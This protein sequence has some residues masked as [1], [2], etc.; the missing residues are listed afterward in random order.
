[1]AE[2]KE[3]SAPAPDDNPSVLARRNWWQTP[4]VNFIARHTPKCRDVTRLL[5]RGMD[6]P[7]P[8]TTRL[9]L[10]THFLI[11]CWCQRY[12]TQLKQMRRFSRR[13]PE[14]I[15]ELPEGQMPRDAKERLRQAL[16]DAGGARP[17]Q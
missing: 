10:R 11:C 9:K 6:E 7:L 5:S 13:F 1:M 16:R 4:L 17:S 12:A 14:H 8:L 2:A 15:G 3:K